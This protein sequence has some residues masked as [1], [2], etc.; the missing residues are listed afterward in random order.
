MVANINKEDNSFA[1]SDQQSIIVHGA[2]AATPSGTDV[3][4]V[5]NGGC[6]E[7]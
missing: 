3:Q 1:K 7:S 2:S 4:I 5:N 6:Y